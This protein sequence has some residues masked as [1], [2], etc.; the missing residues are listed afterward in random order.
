MAKFFKDVVDFLIGFFMGEGIDKIK[1]KVDSTIKNVEERI[2][3]ATIKV[4]KTSILFLMMIVGFIFVL[5]GLAN[6]LNE[7]VYALRDGLGTIVI[8]AV[9]ILLGLFVRVMK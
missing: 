2:E 9:I 1:K 8:G 5:V 4:I 6:Y 7:N 3:K